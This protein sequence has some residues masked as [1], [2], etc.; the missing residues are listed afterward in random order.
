MEKNTLG[1]FTE[2]PYSDSRFVQTIAENISRWC[3]IH[4]L[5]HHIHSVAQTE[6]LRILTLARVPIFGKGISFQSQIRISKDINQ[7][8]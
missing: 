5:N 7:R 3:G 4:R 2:N 1:C 8:W 6:E